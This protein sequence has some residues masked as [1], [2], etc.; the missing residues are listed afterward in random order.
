MRL[1]IGTELENFALR[2]LAT[3][4]CQN[5]IH[6]MVVIGRNL[7]HGPGI[8]VIPN[9]NA[10]MVAPDASGGLLPPAEICFVQDIIVKQRGGVDEFNETA[11]GQIFFRNVARETSAKAQKK[12]AD[13]FATAIKNVSSDFIDQR[14]F[15]I[16]IFTYMC[17]NFFEVVS[18]N[19]PDLVH[20]Q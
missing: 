12:G 3:R 14:S 7:L 1:A 15:S 5:F 8:Q 17:F 4:F 2:H 19:F 9:Q 13:A 10:G 18:V 20:R 11:Q 16:K 6:I